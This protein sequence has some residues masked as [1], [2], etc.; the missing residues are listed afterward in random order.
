MGGRKNNLTFPDHESRGDDHTE[1]EDLTEQDSNDQCRKE[2]QFYILY[3]LIMTQLG[4]GH[5]S[6]LHKYQGC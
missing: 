1:A 5:Q 4:G 2:N 6:D 3:K